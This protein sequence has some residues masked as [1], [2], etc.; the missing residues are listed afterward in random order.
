MFVVLNAVDGIC[1]REEVLDMCMVVEPKIFVFRIRDTKCDFV[2][3][4]E[5]LFDQYMASDNY[6]YIGTLD[7]FIETIRK[8]VKEK[9]RFCIWWLG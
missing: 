3:V 7:E 5:K 4:D 2:F 1:L 8:Q 6:V 9:G